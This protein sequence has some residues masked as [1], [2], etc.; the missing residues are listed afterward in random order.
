M[1]LASSVM[2][3]IV[4]MDKGGV[5]EKSRAFRQKVN[6][7]LETYVSACESQAGIAIPHRIEKGGVGEDT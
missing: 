2:E 7:A 1:E 4:A 5:E 6:S 3:L